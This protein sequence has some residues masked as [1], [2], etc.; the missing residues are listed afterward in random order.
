MSTDH[1]VMGHSVPVTTDAPI[2]SVCPLKC[3]HCGETTW[4]GMP[5]STYAMIAVTVGFIEEHREC[6][7]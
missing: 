1:V 4:I 5:L 2:T 6:R 7:K 3:E